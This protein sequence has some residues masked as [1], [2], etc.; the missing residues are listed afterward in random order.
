M[1][2]LELLREMDK[3]TLLVQRAAEELVQACLEGGPLLNGQE[4]GYF[5]SM[6]ALV[7]LRKALK[8]VHDYALEVARGDAPGLVKF[9]EGATKC[10]RCDGR[11]VIRR[12]GERENEACPMCGGRGFVMLSEP[13]G[14]ADK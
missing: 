11:Q 4:A 1:D 9:V 2:E 5:V 8:V 7:E 10:G 13:K 6:D 14:G 12:H 3:R